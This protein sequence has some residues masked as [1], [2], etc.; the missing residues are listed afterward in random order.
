MLEWLKLTPI[1][2]SDVAFASEGNVLL[3]SDV[4]SSPSPPS[5]LQLEMGMSVSIVDVFFVFFRCATTSYMMSDGQVVS[6]STLAI[7]SP[8]PLGSVTMGR[9]TEE[10]VDGSAGCSRDGGDGGSGRGRESPPLLQ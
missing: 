10:V 5:A 8:S 6:N 3:P 7:I 4:P 1:M 9:P 2:L